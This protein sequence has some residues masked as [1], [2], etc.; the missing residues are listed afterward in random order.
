MQLYFKISLCKKKFPQWIFVN[1]M[2]PTF[3]TESIF[4]DKPYNYILHSKCYAVRLQKKER[5]SQLT[6]QPS[7]GVT[8]E[9]TM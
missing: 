4:A 9:K 3:R 2:L 7:N 1:I 5:P 8:E 6:G